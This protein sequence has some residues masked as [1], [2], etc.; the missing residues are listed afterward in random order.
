MRCLALFSLLALFACADPIGDKE[1]HEDEIPE[2]PNANLLIF[3]D[4]AG[5]PVSVTEILM[6]SDVLPGKELH[7]KLETPTSRVDIKSILQI[8]KIAAYEFYVTS[9]SGMPYYGQ[10]QFYAPSYGGLRKTIT[11]HKGLAWKTKQICSGLK[12]YNY[13]GYE[14][15]SG[16]QQVINILEMN[17][18]SD[19]MKLE[20]QYYPERQMISQ[21]ANGDS[22]IL[23][24]VN[25]SFGSGFTSGSPVDNTYIRVD[26]VNH[27]EIS[28]GPEDT[29]NWWKHEA[30]VWYDGVKELGVISK[31]N[32]PHGAIELYKSTTYPNL[33]SSNVLLIEDGKRSDMNAYSKN[34]GKS[35]SKD[36][37][38]VLAV[39]QDRKLLL[40][41]VDGRWL[42]K[43]AGMSYT[44]IQNFLMTFFNPEFAINMDGGGSTSMFV[45]GY[46]V[47]NYP[48]EGVSGDTYKP[49]PGTFKER[50]LVTYFAIKEK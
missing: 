5:A 44:Q 32:D 41:T 21:V 13:E 12:W 22:K 39:T 36:P 37:R 31:P 25:A 46:K 42:D 23:A 34:F 1:P 28:I 29:S 16:E 18:D 24:V 9:L 35:S 48:C 38:T 3:V 43:A 4:K 6:M 33:F 8:E 47:V 50:G 2:S 27:K 26:G 17:L 30:A 14:P 40:M 10:G 7:I 11:L 49:Y 45:K 19:A 20:F 15:L